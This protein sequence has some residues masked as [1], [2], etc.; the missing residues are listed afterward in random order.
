MHFRYLLPSVFIAGVFIK[1]QLDSVRH[2]SKEFE[3][4]LFA[5]ILFF[6]LFMYMLA[7]LAQ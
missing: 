7:I 2:K 6:A 5:V 1:Y 4:L 3:K